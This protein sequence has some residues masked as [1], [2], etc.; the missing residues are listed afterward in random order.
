MKFAKKRSTRWLNLGFDKFK[1]V[2]DEQ[3]KPRE[4]RPKRLRKT[5][6]KMKK[7]ICKY[8]LS[9]LV[10]QKVRSNTNVLGTETLARKF[11]IFL[12][13]SILTDAY[14]ISENGS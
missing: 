13:F 4:Q 1:L 12:H 9:D 14:E 8:S 2:S 11:I 10:R 3:K 5:G 6:E 7:R